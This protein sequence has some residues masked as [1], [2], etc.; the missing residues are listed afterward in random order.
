MFGIVKDL[1]KDPING[2]GRILN[3]LFALPA[4]ATNQ[5][6]LSAPLKLPKLPGRELKP[7]KIESLAKKYSCIPK[8]FL[9]YYPGGEANLPEH[10]GDEPGERILVQNKPKKLPG[11]PKAPVVQEKSTQLSISSFFP[12]LP[13]YL[14]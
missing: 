1:L 4:D 7:S 6:I 3:E 9:V 2:K 5:E 13:S 8:E 10:D 11:R 14:Q 12:L